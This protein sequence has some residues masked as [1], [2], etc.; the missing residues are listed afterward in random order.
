M[1]R[2]AGYTLVEILCVVVILGIAA[3]MIAP[4]IGTR[5]DLNAAAGARAVMADITYAQN[6][7][8]ATQSMHYV[9]FNAAG[10]NYAICSSMSPQTVVPHP[11]NLGN[12]VQTFGSGD[13]ANCQLVSANI[14][15]GSSV[16]AFDEL[17]AP[18]SYNTTTLATTP[19]SG[20]AQIV[21]RSGQASL[22]ISVESATG[23]MTVQ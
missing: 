20:S 4:S 13:L 1:R 12:F 10:Q 2:R 5:D 23:Q 3:T 14:A 17:G 9:V 21:V 22:T 7:A 19:I 15:G 16:L 6:R 8:I 18:Y 11:V